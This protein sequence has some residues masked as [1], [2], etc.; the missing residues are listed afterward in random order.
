MRWPSVCSWKMGTRSLFPNRTPRT[1]DC[2]ASVLELFRLS[3]VPKKK[4]PP[5]CLSWRSSF[6]PCI[7]THPSRELALL[8]RSSPLHLFVLSG[9]K[10]S[11]AWPIE[12]FLC[13]N[14]CAQTWPRRDLHET[15]PTLP[16]RS[17]CFASPEWLLPR[18]S[19]LNYILFI[20]RFYLPFIFK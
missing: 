14:C 6:V 9:W 20:Y 8:P 12:S 17:V 7:R 13:V 16:I 5:P 18:Y 19:L 4:L 1:W 10:T 3:A 15:G 11:K 2:T